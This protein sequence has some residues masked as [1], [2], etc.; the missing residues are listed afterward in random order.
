MR[1]LN[2]GKPLRE[3]GHDAALNEITARVGGIER[4][5]KSLLTIS[6]NFRVLERMEIGKCRM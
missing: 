4:S 6:V 1:D 2:T 3:K 5:S